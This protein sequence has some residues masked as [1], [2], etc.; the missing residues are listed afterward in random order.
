MTLIIVDGGADWAGLEGPIQERFPWISFL[1]CVSHLGSLVM[2]DIGK[3]PEVAEIVETVMDI[4]NWFSS[5]QKVAAIVQKMC[6][7]VYGKTRKFLWA[8]E[9]CFMTIILLLKQFKCMMGAL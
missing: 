6:L 8:P 9:T 4:Q 1:H 7:K 2:N 5:S 3:I